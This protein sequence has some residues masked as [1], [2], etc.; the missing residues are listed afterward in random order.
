[1]IKPDLWLIKPHVIR[2]VIANVGV[3][4][5]NVLFTFCARKLQCTNTSVD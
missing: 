3:Y 2:Y 1:M 4:I 5:L